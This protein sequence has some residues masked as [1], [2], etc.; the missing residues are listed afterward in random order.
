MDLTQR[1]DR[2][3]AVAGRYVLYR[4]PF[5]PGTYRRYVVGWLDRGAMKKMATPSPQAAVARLPSVSGDVVILTRE[6]LAEMLMAQWQ[7]G[8]IRGQQESYHGP[9]AT[10][11]E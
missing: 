11:C 6:K 1:V 8:F 3:M 2:R 5:C 7:A 4:P 10:L 9:L